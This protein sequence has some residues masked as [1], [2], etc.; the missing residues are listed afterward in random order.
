MS[1]DIFIAFVDGEFT[2]KYTASEISLEATG[3]RLTTGL[4]TYGIKFNSWYVF[5]GVNNYWS[6]V[7]LDEVPSE[8]KLQLLLLV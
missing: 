8:V 3:N 2:R 6:H 7:P 5:G 4:L 1:D